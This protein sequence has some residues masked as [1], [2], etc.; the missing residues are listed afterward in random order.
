MTGTETTKVFAD[1][2][3]E[4]I[5]QSGK[6]M[7]TLSREIGISAAALSKYQNDQGE[8]GVNALCKIAAYFHVTADY[9]LGCS[10]NRTAE[11]AAV[12]KQL[13]LS[14]RAVEKLKTRQKETEVWR[15]TA[16]GMYA[17]E[18]LEFM[19]QWI[20]GGLSDQIFRQ[21]VGY[22]AA[23]QE[24]RRFYERLQALLKEE[25]TRL[26]ALGRGAY[27]EFQ[28]DTGQTRKIHQTPEELEQIRLWRAQQAIQTFF[29]VLAQKERRELLALQKEI[30]QTA[31]VW[32]G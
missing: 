6:D 31:D 2:L 21:Y 4:L 11:N 19:N 25:N 20:G 18:Y 7:K 17:S 29:G 3:G 1:R 32:D 13:G 24:K 14:D 28:A 16:R 23:L 5:A 9:L 8:A 22:A 27:R 15:G 12:G 30:Q 26:Q 10:R